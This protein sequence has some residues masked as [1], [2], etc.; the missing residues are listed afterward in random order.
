MLSNGRLLEPERITLA[1]YAVDQFEIRLEQVEL[2]TQK[3][4]E[5]HGLTDEPRRESIFDEVSVSCN[6]HRVPACK[7]LH[8]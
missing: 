7:D 2:P 8:Q 1:D 6:R 3:L 5:R 4:L